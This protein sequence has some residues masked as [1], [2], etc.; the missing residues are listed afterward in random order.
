[1]KN[2]ILLAGKII[3][4]GIV[5]WFLLRTLDIDRLR[6][7]AEVI[8]RRFVGLAIICSGLTLPMLAFR[9]KRVLGTFSV[10]ITV[11]RAMRINLIGMCSSN[12]F[13][14]IL[15]GDLIRPLYLRR[16][17]PDQEIPLYA[18]VF[19]ERMCGLASILI[20][21]LVSSGWLAFH[22]K[23]WY[24]IS[25]TGAISAGVIL[26]LFFFNWLS[27]VTVPLPAFL[28]RFQSLARRFSSQFILSARNKR[29]LAGTIG[30]S[31]LAQVISISTYWII[32]A[33]TGI[34]A[35]P[36]TVVIAVS[37]AWLV[38]LIPISLNGL[39]LREGSMV[40]MLTRF[41]IAP[42]N[43]GIAVLL[44]LLPAFI[45][46]IAGA[47]LLTTDARRGHGETERKGTDQG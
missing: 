45:F 17:F 14:G 13:P 32:L 20:L 12:F 9:W 8:D 39:G 4:S 19:F 6:R 5:I 21:G 30:W 1:M 25:I 35:D 7:M 27:A 15:G 29:L 10:H 22:A 34:I 38:A 26:I 36:V 16:D 47:V 11:M 23:D 44:G 28:N 43:A 33:G 41:G 2:K 31:L 24:Y 3:I 37:L 42:D 18:S 46:S 40:Y